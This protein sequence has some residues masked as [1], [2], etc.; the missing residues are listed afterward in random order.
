MASPT[1]TTL[2]VAIRVSSAS[3]LSRV[4][5]VSVT[6]NHGKGD[7]QRRSAPTFPVSRF[8][9]L[10]VQGIRPSYLVRQLS[11]PLPTHRVLLAPETCAALEI[12]CTPP[13]AERSQR[14]C[15]A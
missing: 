14:P 13:S 5:R 3:M 12:R 10:A 4:S 6:L 2:V 8:P 7:K 15:A 1:T 9:F 11:C